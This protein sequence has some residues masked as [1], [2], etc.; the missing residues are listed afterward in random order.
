MIK[1]YGT[2]YNRASRNIWMLEELGADYELVE[3]NTQAGDSRTADFLKI[4]PN[5]HV[6]V[7][8][9]GDLTMC[10]SVAINL[11]LADKYQQLMPGT[12]QSRAL[13]YHWTVWAMTEAEPPMLMV[14]RH[15]MLLPEEERDESVAAEAYDNIQIPVK[16]LEGALE[17]KDYLGGSEFTVTDLNVCSVMGFSAFLQYDFSPYPNVGAWMQRC[18]SR[19]AAQ[20]SAKMAQEAMAAAMG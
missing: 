11:Y 15:R 7:L 2:A 5:G 16:V 4:N 8:Q 20:K 14:L 12:A 19:P 13:S 10:E 6:P 17:G 18:G 1:L 9:D 3:V